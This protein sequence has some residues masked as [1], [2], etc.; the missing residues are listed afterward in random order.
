MNHLLQ[1][2][3]PATGRRRPPLVGALVVACAVYFAAP[4]A[5]AQQQAAL[6]LSASFSSPRVELELTDARVRITVGAEGTPHIDARVEPGG[7]TTDVRLEVDHTPGSVTRIRRPDADGP[8]PTITV[9]LELSVDQVL[10]VAGARLELEISGP[11]PDPEVL[12]PDQ[13]PSPAAPTA[14]DSTSTAERPPEKSESP[15]T[16]VVVTDSQ[17]TARNLGALSLTATG[18]MVDLSTSVGSSELRL[19]GSA[20][21]LHR[22]RGSA[23]IEAFDSETTIEDAEG[24]VVINLDGGALT[25]NRST[26]AIRGEFY[27]ADVSIVTASGALQ[28]SGSDS[29]IR[30]TD[31]TRAQTRISGDELRVALNDV[32]GP[33]HLALNGGSLG[34]DVVE[35]RVDLQLTAR[36]E[37]EIGDIRGDLAA[38]LSDGVRAEIDGVTGHTRVQLQYGELDL[39]DLKSLDLATQGGLVTGRGIR[40]IQ[41]LEA[42]DSDLELLLDDVNGRPKI[43]LRGT[44]D[45]RVQLSTPCRVVAKLPESPFGDHLRVSGCDFDFDGTSKRSLRRGVDGRAPVV[46][47][48]TLDENAS[49]RV[50][51]RP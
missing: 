31:V 50:D 15:N 3:Q 48:A 38:V 5:E 24:G 11:P 16:T 27:G 47:E 42:T 36:A 22:M 17:V 14:K 9:D 20:A 4:E 29:S 28:L 32:G 46:L 1:P 6:P 34:A 51:G 23:V 30:V 40:S 21:F 43:D 49:L 12:P 8:Q 10:S 18:G 35:G 33:V 39:S 7:S 37:A 41:R 26:S 45:A 19:D 2:R 13:D 44:T 25:V